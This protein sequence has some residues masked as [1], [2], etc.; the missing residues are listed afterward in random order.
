MKSRIA[1]SLL[2]FFICST[3]SCMRGRKDK[4][5]RQREREREGKKERKKERMEG[6]KKA[7][8]NEG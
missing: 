4:T 5:E 6:G 8:T 1:S 2:L 3:D 7:Y